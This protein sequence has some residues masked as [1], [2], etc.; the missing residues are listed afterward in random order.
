MEALVERA[1]GLDVHKKQVTVSI[2][3]PGKGNRLRRETRTFG[4]VTRELERLREW[5]RAEGIT[6]VGMESTGI[7]WRPV[8]AVLEGHF[9]LIVANA[10]HIKNVPGRKTDVKDAE[11]LAN[12]VRHGL[13]RASFVPGPLLREL[14]ELTRYRRKLVE[15]QSAQRNRVQKLLETA[16]IKIG[17][18]ASDVFG[19]SGMRILRALVDGEQAPATMAG[20]AVGKLR[21]KR[22]ELE[23]ALEGCM[24][25]A[26]RFLLGEQLALLDQFAERIQNIEKR[27]EAKIVP[28][29]EAVALLAELPGVDNLLAVTIIAE[30]GDDMR[31]FPTAAHAAAWAGVAPGNNESGGKQ[32]RSR[33]RRGNVFLK[34]ALV[35]AAHGAAR[36][37]ASYYSALFKRKAPAGKQKAL[38]TVAHSILVAA[39]H[40]LKNGTAYR[41]LG[42]DYFDRL[43]QNRTANR[44][45]RRLEALGYEVKPKVA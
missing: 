21:N 10:Q 7:Y 24:T 39:Y 31:V 37:K 19:V 44:L 35:E 27:I 4:T 20:L 17:S 3:V 14:R 2:I 1:C 15:A 25:E 8:Y 43:N 26:H 32:R 16:N 28:Y 36:T 23:L 22:A 45:I 38:V 30:M 13:I 11:W 9:T 40:M 33:A 41:D 29:R 6:H 5:L 34:T 18:V 42:G 12:L